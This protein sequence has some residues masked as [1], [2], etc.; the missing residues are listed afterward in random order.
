[1]AQNTNTNTNKNEINVDVLVKAL[2]DESNEAL[3]NLT[4]DKII[5]MNLTILQELQFSKE[6]VLTY[7]KKLKG[8]RYVDEIKDVKYGAFIKW[9]PITDPTYLPLNIGG[10]ICDIKLI[11]TGIIIVC[12]NFMH[13]HYQIKMDECLLFQKLSNQELVLL[14][15]LD[16]LTMT[17]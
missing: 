3:M 2:D 10:I 11:D 7:M 15:A 1:M 13:K 9:I 12:K 6:T 5:K 16:H 8:Y 4:T 17:K 14:S